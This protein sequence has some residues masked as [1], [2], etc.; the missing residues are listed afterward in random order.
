M[1]SQEY[2]LRDPGRRFIRW[3]TQRTTPEQILVFGDDRLVVI[4]QHADGSLNDTLIGFEHVVRVDWALILLYAYVKFTWV[5]DHTFK[6][7][8]IE[9]NGVGDGLI[10]A[11]LERLRKTQ[12]DPES[13]SAVLESLDHDAIRKALSLKFSNYLRYALIRRI[14]AANS[15]S[16]KL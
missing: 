11:E 13:D 14:S 10:R 15:L 3:D 6:T 4:E 12:H 16:A 1:P 7:L 9:Y 8:R 5:A 2:S